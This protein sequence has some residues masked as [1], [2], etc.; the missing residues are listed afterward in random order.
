LRAAYR[1]VCMFAGKSLNAREMGII[2]L[3]SR[4][5]VPTIRYYSLFMFKQ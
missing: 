5:I 2:E 3:I 1:T 4:H